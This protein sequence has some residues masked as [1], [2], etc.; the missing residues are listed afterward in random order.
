MGGTGSY[1]GARGQLVYAGVYVA[2]V[3]QFG[4]MR[5]VDAALN[6]SKAGIESN[7]LSYTRRRE[8]SIGS[9]SS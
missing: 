3:M 2:K 1:M 8:F 9:N 6:E 7:W 4:K 5:L